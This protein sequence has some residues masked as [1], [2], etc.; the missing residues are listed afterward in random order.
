MWTRLVV[1]GLCLMAIGGC[2]AKFWDDDL[3]DQMPFITVP[4]KAT[5]SQGVEALR[6]LDPA[7]SVPAM[8]PGA[9]DPLTPPGLITFRRIDAGSGMAGVMPNEPGREPGDT[10]QGYA[11]ARYWLGVTELTRAQWTSLA[12]AGGHVDQAMLSPWLTTEP[13]DQAG[14]GANQPRLPAVNLSRD[15]VNRVL[16]DW[17]R[18]AAGIASLR[19]P[20]PTEWEHACRSGSV[21]PYP[22]GEGDPNLA[23][24]FAVVRET[25]VQ[26][27]PTVVA[28]GRQPNALGLWDMQGNVWELVATTGPDAELRGGSWRDNLISARAGNRQRLDRGLAHALAG[29]RLVLEAP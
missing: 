8:T 18:A 12:V 2:K 21:G 9:G 5:P 3:E 4:I 26:I 6:R 24:A 27:G 28:Q 7:L 16:A 15:L 22:W 17:N 10:W 13:I 20:T 11:V 23:R 14:G 29:V 1:A 19:L 25:R